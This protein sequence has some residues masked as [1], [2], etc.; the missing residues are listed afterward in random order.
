MKS[1]GP[2]QNQPMAIPQANFLILA[3]RARILSATRDPAEL[4]AS[5]PETMSA[6]FAPIF[7]RLY[8]LLAGKSLVF[9]VGAVHGFLDASLDYLKEPHTRFGQDLALRLMESE[10]T[11]VGREYLDGYFKG[12]IEAN[13]TLPGQGMGKGAVTQ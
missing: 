3:A 11:P 9:H 4:A 2:K 7:A 1:R 10:S 12:R 8:P 13:T 5:L 6:E